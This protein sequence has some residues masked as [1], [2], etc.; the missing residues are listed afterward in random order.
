MC[1]TLLYTLDKVHTT[2]ARSMHIQHITSSKSPTHFQNYACVYC[3][4]TI[5]LLSLVN[6]QENTCSYNCY[7]MYTCRWE[8]M[9]GRY[10]FSKKRT[11]STECIYMHVHRETLWAFTQQERKATLKQLTQGISAHKPSSAMGCHSWHW[12]WVVIATK[13]QETNF[14]HVCLCCCTDWL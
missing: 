2:V 9:T 14:P 12:P 1:L 4:L 13:A 11:H 8:T 7:A 5:H 3:T 6:H 10:L